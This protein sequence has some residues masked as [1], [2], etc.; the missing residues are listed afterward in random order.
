MALDS[1]I[2]KLK[3]GKGKKVVQVIT[4]RKGKKKGQKS[5]EWNM[6]IKTKS[7]RET[8]LKIKKGVLVKG[9]Y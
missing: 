6:T 2:I 9:I 7:R 5:E 1:R 4:N 8:R 3:L